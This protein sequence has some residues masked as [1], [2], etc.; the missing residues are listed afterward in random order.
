MFATRIVWFAEE[1]PEGR[2]I[3]VVTRQ[4]VRSGTSVAANYRAACLGRSKAEF[5]AKLHIVLKEVDETV[6]WLEVLEESAL[7]NSKDLDELKRE[8]KELT[9][10]FISSLKTSRSK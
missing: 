2:S 3:N 7:A 10:I 8:G 1:L 6:Y 5:N 9:A 4:L